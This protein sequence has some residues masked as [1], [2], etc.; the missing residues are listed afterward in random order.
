MVETG[1]QPSLPEPYLKTRPPWTRGGLISGQVK[2]I[3]R[4]DCLC[5]VESNGRFPVVPIHIVDMNP[6]ELW[7]FFGVDIRDLEPTAVAVATIERNPS[8]VYITPVVH[9]ARS[10]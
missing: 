9:S 7:V 10:M 1:G 4:V 3:D 5:E 8:V 2:E 6:E